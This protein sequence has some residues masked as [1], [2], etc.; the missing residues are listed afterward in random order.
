[1]WLDSAFS[2]TRVATSSTSGTVS[3]KTFSVHRYQ[4]GRPSCFDKAETERLADILATA[5]GIGKGPVNT[6]IAGQSRVPKL[7]RVILQGIAYHHAGL[8]LDDRRMVERAFIGNKI[9]ALCATSTLAMGVNLPAH[10]V[11]IKGTKAW[12]GGY[13][14]LDQASLLQMIGRAGRPGF[15]TSG[16]AVI[17]TDN[18]SKAR[19]EKLATSGLEPAN[20]KLLSKL[21]EVIN[22]EI[23]QL[24]ITSTETA[25]NW[26]KDSVLCSTETP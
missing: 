18:A 19:F 9:R 20:S 7:Q 17:M 26:I 2:G 5:N 22:T 13:Q 6:D 10:L 15:D 4:R 1:M 8:E 11:I 21:V 25:L 23:S 3:K 16:T 24:V 14:D 12:R